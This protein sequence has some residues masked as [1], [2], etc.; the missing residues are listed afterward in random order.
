MPP[1]TTPIEQRAWTA[2]RDCQCRTAIA[3]PDWDPKACPASRHHCICQRDGGSWVEA[4]RAGEGVSADQPGSDPHSCTC[5]HEAP[6]K[7]WLTSA[8]DRSDT[9]PLRC[10]SVSIHQCSCFT[11]PW[12]C[13]HTF[14][15]CACVCSSV[16][17]ARSAKISPQDCR[18][19][20]HSCVCLIGGDADPLCRGVKDKSHPDWVQRCPHAPRT[21][22]T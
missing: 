9:G 16:A 18:A 15:P 10:R 5:H 8:S 20:T 6:T 3:A 17:H 22:P 14:G 21:S 2:R 4:C 13:R 19:S 12:D 7:P 11:R 1:T